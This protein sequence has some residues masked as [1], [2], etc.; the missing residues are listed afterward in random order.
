MFLN[1]SSCCGSKNPTRLKS[2]QYPIDVSSARDSLTQALDRFYT[3][4]KCVPIEMLINAEELSILQGALPNSEFDIT[5][6][7]LHI[8]KIRVVV[9]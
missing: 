4:Y 6:G 8:R 3:N 1:K 9:I 7:V 2:T 5:N